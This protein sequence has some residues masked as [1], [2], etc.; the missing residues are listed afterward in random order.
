MAGV[1]SVAASAAPDYLD[2]LNDEQREAVLA[3]EGAVLM[4]ARAPAPARRGR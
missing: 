3:T 2:G 4:L 1:A